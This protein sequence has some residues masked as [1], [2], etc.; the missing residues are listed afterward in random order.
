VSTTFELLT[1]DAVP[2][3]ACRWP[4]LGT[5][6]ATVVLVHGFTASSSEPKVVAVAEQLAGAGLEVVGYD[7]RGHGQSGGEATLGDLERFDV[8]AATTVAREATDPIVLVGASVGAIAALRHVASAPGTVA[9]IVTVSCPARWRLPRNAR[10][11]T[12]AAMTQTSLGRWA[13][14]RYVGVRIARN[15]QRPAPPIDLVNRVGA[16]VAV[17]HGRADPFIPSA[18]ATALHGAARDPRRLELVDGM[19]HAFE[20][21]SIEPIL[22]AIDWILGR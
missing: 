18:D 15:V 16:P 22:G 4:A 12:S 5:P 17:I 9:G 6:R 14:R 19:G 2:L 3:H 13:A 21:P 11:L 20:A 8:A 1:D 7:A 10:G